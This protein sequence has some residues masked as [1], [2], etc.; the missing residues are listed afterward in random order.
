MQTHNSHQSEELEESK[1]IGTISPN[2]PDQNPEFIEKKPY[3]YS[4]KVVEET[5]EMKDFTRLAKLEKAMNT[6]EDSKV[7]AELF[8]EKTAKEVLEIKES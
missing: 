4:K 6:F 1:V 5:K 3:G 2:D 8:D 7:E